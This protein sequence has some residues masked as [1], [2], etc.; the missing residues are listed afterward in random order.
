MS[1]ISEQKGILLFRQTTPSLLETLL[2]QGGSLNKLWACWNAC[3]APCRYFHPF[4]SFLSRPEATG[5]CNAGDL[6]IIGLHSLGK[7]EFL[8]LLGLKKGEA[9][10]EDLLRRGIRGPF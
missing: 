1:A 7:D 6:E 9:V 5:S 2:N 3:Y 4:F 8:D 10:S